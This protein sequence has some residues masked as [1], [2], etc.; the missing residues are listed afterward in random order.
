MIPDLSPCNYYLWRTPKNIVYVNNPYCL[1][2][3]KDN[4]PREIA[5]IS[6]QGLS[7]VKKYFQMVPGLLGGWRLA[8]RDSSKKYG[9]RELKKENAF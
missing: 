3:L 5:D 2:K 6:R 7:C 8:L 1:Q 9:K 4:T